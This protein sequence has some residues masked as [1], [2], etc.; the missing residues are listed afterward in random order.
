MNTWLLL[1]CY[2]V[3][4]PDCVIYKRW[5]KG[6]KDCI[7]ISNIPRNPDDFLA[8]PALVDEYVSFMEHCKNLA[9]AAFKCGV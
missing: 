5:T 1:W 2:I 8:D 7:G 4:L 3:N 6:S 9:I